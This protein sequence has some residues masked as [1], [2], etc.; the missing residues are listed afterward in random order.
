MLLILDGKLM[1]AIWN[2]ICN[3]VCFMVDILDGNSYH[4]AHTLRT[5]IARIRLSDL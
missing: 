4:V 2:K 1:R 3:L 5:K